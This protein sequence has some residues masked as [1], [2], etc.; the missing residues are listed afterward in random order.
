MWARAL[1]ESEEAYRACLDAALKAKELEHERELERRLD[2]LQER[3]AEEM[4]RLEKAKGGE[5]DAAVAA[6]STMRLTQEAAATQKDQELATTQ[7]KISSRITLAP[8]ARGTT[9]RWPC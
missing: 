5:H 7:A 1:R 3:H 4:V 9:R 8:T 6:M 2:E